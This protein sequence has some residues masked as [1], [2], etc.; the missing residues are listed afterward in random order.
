[1]TYDIGMV[2]MNHEQR[3]LFLSGLDC[4][5]HQDISVHTMS[6]IHPCEHALC[7]LGGQK[8]APLTRH[9]QHHSGAELFSTW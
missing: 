6:H 8:L 3:S 4:N 9:L 2:D 1:M 5:S 7:L